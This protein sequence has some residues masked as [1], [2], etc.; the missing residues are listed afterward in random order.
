MTSSSLAACSSA[1]AWSGSPL[2]Q[3]LVLIYVLRHRL[4]A[5]FSTRARKCRSVKKRSTLALQHVLDQLNPDSMC[6]LDT[7][8]SPDCATLP[9]SINL[10]DAKKGQRT[11]DAWELLLTAVDELQI[12]SSL[13][14]ARARGSQVVGRPQSKDPRAKDQACIGHGVSYTLG[15]SSSWQLAC[16]GIHAHPRYV[17]EGQ[18]TNQTTPHTEGLA[19]TCHTILHCR[20]GHRSFEVDDPENSEGTE[21][22]QKWE[23]STVEGEAP[24]PSNSRP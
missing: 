7:A 22:T 11:S 9:F 15:L 1:F 13:L 14:P 20:T 16:K 12:G 4:H 10:L 8:T 19:Q 23:C 6:K 3:L 2:L 17:M 5:T 24:A 18:S 21:L